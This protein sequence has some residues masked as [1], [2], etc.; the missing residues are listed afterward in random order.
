[1]QDTYILKKCFV[2]YYINDGSMTQHFNQKYESSF[3]ALFN[4]LSAY[5]KDAPVLYYIHYINMRT[6]VNVLGKSDYV[7]KK[8]YLR[9]ILKNNLSRLR[10]VKKEDLSFLDKILIKIMIMCCPLTLLFIGKVYRWF[11][12]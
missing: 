7:N 3:E 1:M 8:E 11:H 5:F 9:K 10:M 6:M 12:K 4:S 2:N